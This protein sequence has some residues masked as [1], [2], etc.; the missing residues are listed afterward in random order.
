M[1]NLE[2]I[3]SAF[4]NWSQPWN[5]YSFV[6]SNVQLTDWEK[7]KFEEVWETAM[8]S[9]NWKDADLILCCKMTQNK[10]KKMYNLSDD[11]I[12]KI[13]RAVSYDWK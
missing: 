4:N 13:V 10:L 9:T 12:G 3:I 6:K 5:F 8:D 1:E 2:T 7:E 11:T